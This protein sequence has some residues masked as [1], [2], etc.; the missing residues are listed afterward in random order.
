[1]PKEYNTGDFITLSSANT[2]RE[3]LTG[4]TLPQNYQQAA[5][6][7][8]LPYRVPSSD[9]LAGL[10]EVIGINPDSA[11]SVQ[12]FAEAI[13]DS[14]SE[15]ETVLTDKINAVLE[16]SGLAGLT[17]K[18]TFSSDEDG[19]IIVEG[20]VRKD[21]LELLQQKINADAELAELLKTHKAKQNVLAE[22]QQLQ[23]DEPDLSKDELSLVISRFYSETSIGTTPLA[24]FKRGA[25]GGTEESVD[26][27]ESVEAMRNKV[28]GAIK[29][30]KDTFAL[31]NSDYEIAD[32]NLTLDKNGNT[33]IDIKTKGGD[34]DDNQTAERFINSL[35]SDSS[36]EEIAG[37][38]FNAHDDEH[39]DVEEYRHQLVL[40][41]DGY[42]IESP[43]ADEAALTEIQQ[44]GGDIFS[45]LGQYFDSLF[46]TD[47][48]P[49]ELTLDDNGK[50]SIDW[51]GI[52]NSAAKQAGKV[53][54]LLNDTDNPNRILPDGLKPIAEKLLD[55][56][57]SAEKLHGK[58]SK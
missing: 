43:E 45:A 13:Q 20:N 4:Y 40:T 6:K 56:Q 23:Q 44:I 42:K 31:H 19:N 16:Q 55:Y 8:Q 30:Y 57:E 2:Q 24:S 35:L 12:S 47:R 22:L 52:N 14:I 27:D 39:G 25:L 7:P 51:D 1:M 28:A 33:V 3:V 50:L 29:K 34:T 41:K 9:S 32:W 49:F 15:D 36:T 11:D 21:K 58:Y 37:K 48:Q 38:I 26:I 53:L 54:E 10:A 18:I 17:R 46:G 5:V